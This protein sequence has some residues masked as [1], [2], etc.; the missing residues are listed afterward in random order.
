MTVLLPPKQQCRY[1]ALN[2]QNI[3]EMMI[4]KSSSNKSNMKMK[5]NLE[6]KPL[7][8]VCTDSKWTVPVWKE[9][10]FPKFSS[11]MKNC[12]SVPVWKVFVCAYRFPKFSSLNVCE[13]DYY[14][15]STVWKL[16]S[17]VRW[18]N[19]QSWGSLRQI[20]RLA[21]PHPWS[22][23]V[24]LGWARHLGSKSDLVVQKTNLHKVQNNKNSVLFLFFNMRPH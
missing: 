22:F 3:N 15:E 7:I 21:T 12:Q 20:V 13:Y 17:G 6:F 1:T 24:S 19:E 18:R 16:L 11:R 10:W 14:V 9:C 2:E 23:S 8:S 5:G 4:R